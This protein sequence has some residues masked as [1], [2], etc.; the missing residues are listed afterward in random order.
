MPVSII[1]ASFEAYALV[2]TGR[3]E[4]NSREYSKHR[5]IAWRVS[6]LSNSGV[7]TTQPVTLGGLCKDYE[8]I[9]DDQGVTING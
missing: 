8:R 4:G 3:T 9:V 1:P 6:E 7:M 2:L 5:V